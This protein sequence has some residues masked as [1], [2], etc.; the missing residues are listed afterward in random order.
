[1]T[2]NRLRLLLA[3]DSEDDAL[4]LL[5][6]L[7]KDGWEIEYYVR[8]D[9]R[10]GM[11]AALETGNWD[12]VITDHNMPSFDSKEALELIR[13]SNTDVP[14][15]IVSGS[16]G[17]ELAVSMMKSGAADYIMKDNLIRLGAAI[18][19]ELHEAKSRAARRQA[20]NQLQ[21]MAFHDS[22]TD[23][24]NRRE[25]E[26]ALSDA[27]HKAR[28]NN[29]VHSFMYLDLDQFK[30]INDTCGHM[31][32]DE[33]LRQ[34]SVLLKRHIRDSD[35]LARLGGD[36]FGVVLRNCALNQAE[37]LADKLRKAVES[38][39]FIWEKRPFSSRVSIGL[40]DITPDSSS[41]DEVLSNADMA[42]FAA[43]S[44]GRNRVHVY[45]AKDDELALQRNEM[46]WVSRINSA[47]EDDRLLLYRQPIVP[48]CDNGGV[49]HSEVLLR[50]QGVDGEIITPGAF[51]PAAERYDLMQRL[52]RWVVNA[53]FTHLGKRHDQSREG[54]LH[55]INLSGTSLS[56]PGFFSY[57]QERITRL[58][59]PPQSICFE[60]T[61]TAAISNLNTTVSFIE[62]IRE[63]GC[64]FALDDFGTGL[65]SFSYLKS[66][67]VDFLKVDGS[68][69]Q[70]VEEDEMSRA[71]VDAINTI[72]HVAGLKTIAEFVERDETRKVLQAMGVDFAQGYGI[73]RPE[74]L[75]D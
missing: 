28:R 73:H 38:H 22:L 49:W 5:H 23:L 27:L 12:L 7:K 41:I 50:M 11:Q 42:C 47:L 74:P 68:F 71:I 70:Q 46:Q 58:K 3:E 72:G 48:L 26:Q 69:V 66:L 55:F 67:P 56:D 59:V 40:V 35:L 61:E 31:A 45:T 20:E 6:Y 16:I 63:M 64:S 65:S 60:V 29:E 9:T 10:E 52:D 30:V 14:V 53:I 2:D 62:E 32:G 15:I 18:E 24:K 21:H 36:E 75:D 34:I 8:V 13:R 33:L 17:E 4:L 1:M 25:L 43:K 51:I 54:Q 39:K 44:R 57:I 19:R 37:A